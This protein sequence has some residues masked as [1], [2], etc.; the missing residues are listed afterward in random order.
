MILVI[1]VGEVGVCGIVG[2]MIGIGGI[3]IDI[4]VIRWSGIGGGVGLIVGWPITLRSAKG[5]G[6]PDCDQYKLKRHKE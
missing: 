2:T 6:H 4:A 3:V 1:I 5:R